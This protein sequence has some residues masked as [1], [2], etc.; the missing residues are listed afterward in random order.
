VGVLGYYFGTREIVEQLEAMN[1]Q[2]VR[3]YYASG[4]RGTQAGLT[5]GGKAWGACYQPY[6]VAVSGGEPW[7]RERA[8]RIA[9]EAAGLAGVPTRIEDDDLLT[10]QEFIGEGYGIPTTACIDAI[11]MVAE[12]EGILL[13]PVYTGKAMA[14]L[15]DHVRRGS[16]D[17]SSTV[18]FLHT[19]GA[20]GLFAHAN[21]F[22]TP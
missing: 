3:L 2:P 8:L 19:G 14:C 6:G 13:D 7:K 22:T 21:A 4:S 18:V 20:P 12:C 15:I 17:P 9:N 5:L 1:E 10:D 11:N 16:L